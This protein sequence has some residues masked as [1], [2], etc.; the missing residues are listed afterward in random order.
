MTGVVG[1]GPLGVVVGTGVGV[2]PPM[3]VG[4]TGVVG[5]GPVGVVVGTG[6]GLPPPIV[7]GVTG[8]ALVVV[9]AAGGS[10]TTKYRALVDASITELSAATASIIRA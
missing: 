8:A 1:T 7:V 3:V 6:V 10:S 2:P 9:G 4:V 5:A